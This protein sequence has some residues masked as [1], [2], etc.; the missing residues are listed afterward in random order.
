MQLF[1]AKSTPL[2]EFQEMLIA[3][4]QTGDKLDVSKLTLSRIKPQATGPNTTVTITGVLGS[5]ITGTIALG[6]N[7]IDLSKFYNK[8]GQVTKKPVVRIAAMASSTKA[9]A[10]VILQLNTALGLTLTDTGT[11]KDL[12]AVSFTVPTKGAKT[13][14]TLTANTNITG[15]GATSLR[16][17]PGTTLQI[18]FENIGAVLTSALLQRNTTPFLN[19]NMVQNTAGWT[20]D[21]NVP[22]VIP[23]A[24]TRDLDFTADLRLT[25]T[26]VSTDF[27]IKTGGTSYDTTYAFERP[28]L[29][30]INA[31][32]TGAGL[33]AIRE[34]WSWLPNSSSYDTGLAKV[35]KVK[36][37][38]TLSAS[39]LNPKFSHV[40]VIPYVAL[41]TPNELVES[42]LYLHL[43]ILV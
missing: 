7:R 25:D 19:G 43:N 33:P 20:V 26:S 32:L 8:F 14:V 34:D 42:S 41:E 12:N 5:G 39:R 10:D 24:I 31:R 4:A 36:T 23:D 11:Y 28:L 27:I 30:K 3:Q 21:I 18:E 2:S 6:Y 35:L 13:A 1:R 22:K 29:S 9:L 40:L 38:V 16:L 37:D 15:T 17:V